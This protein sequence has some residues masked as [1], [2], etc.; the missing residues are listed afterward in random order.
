MTWLRSQLGSRSAFSMRA[1][2]L[3]EEGT[4]LAVLRMRLGLTLMRDSTWRW[5]GFGPSAKK[6]VRSVRHTTQK[7]AG[8]VRISLVRRCRLGATS[9]RAVSGQA[10]PFAR[11]TARRQSAW[12]RRVAAAGARGPECAVDKPERGDL[13]AALPHA[14]GQAGEEAAPSAVVSVV[15]GRT[16]GTRRRSLW[17]WSRRC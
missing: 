11:V 9:A 15:R 7:S 17:N 1:Y 6:L 14:D 10:Q 4:R 5:L 2:M 8:R 12:A 16:T 13:F 3:A